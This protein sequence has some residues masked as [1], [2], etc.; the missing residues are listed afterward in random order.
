MP[1]PQHFDVTIIGAGI[2]GLAAAARLAKDGMRTLLIERNQQI[3]GRCSFRHIRGCEFDIGALYVGSRAVELLQS[4][5]QK[6]LLTRPILVGVRWND[7]WITLPPGRRMLFDLLACGVSPFEL[8]RFSLNLPRL[9]GNEIFEHST[10]LGELVETLSK[11]SPIRETLFSGLGVSG[12]S[13]YQMPARDMQL[14]KL[15]MGTKIGNPRALEGGNMQLA[16]QL[17]EVYIHSVVSQS[18]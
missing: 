17:H 14:G 7:H 12:V 18:E 3:G 4:E 8:A 2:S 1:A 10:N 16:E 6:T 13:P 15:A 11:S 9:F 5:F